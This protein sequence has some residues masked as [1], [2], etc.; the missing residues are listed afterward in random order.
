MWA[1]PPQRNRGG[2]IAGLAVGGLILLLACGGVSWWAGTR[3]TASDESSSG[4]TPSSTRSS[5]RYSPS[6]TASPSPTSRSS[7]LLASSTTDTTPFL[8]TQF[9][10]PSFVSADGLSYTSSGAG[11]YS[12]CLDA[13]G[14]KIDSLM[15]DNGCGSMAVGIYLNAAQDVMV[16]LMVIPLPESANATAVFEA[17]K[18]SATRSELAYFCSGDSLPGNDVCN[19]ASTRDVLRYIGY[20]NYFRY[21]IIA[22][23]VYVDGRSSGEKDPLATA[24]HDCIAQVEA[25]MLVVY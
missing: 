7:G 25:S 8:L 1:P 18:D 20:I 11:F 12:A 21:A 22:S 4:A 24:G 3:H 5:P 16:G 9:F 6:A 10:R 13:G 23:E 17:I 2:L 15:E 14:S 19:M